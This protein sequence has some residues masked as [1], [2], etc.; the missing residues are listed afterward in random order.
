MSQER[1]AV[2]AIV[3]LGG[4]AATPAVLEVTRFRTLG[5]FGRVLGHVVLWLGGSWLT[6]AITFD[7]FVASFPFVIG[8]GYL[9]RT[10]RGRYRVHR[11]EGTCPR[12]EG[13]LTL[14]R[15]SKIPLPYGLVC[16]R[17]HHESELRV[18]A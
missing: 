15:G 8:L 7:P 14:E 18:A 5:W 12:C 17:C 6:L 11:F 3:H 13:A 16:Y 4:H 9:Y 10:I 2:P 1:G